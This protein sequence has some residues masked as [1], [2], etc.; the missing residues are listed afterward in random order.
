MNTYLFLFF[1]YTKKKSKIS[2]FMNVT[3][4][5]TVYGIWITFWYV[6]LKCPAMLEADHRVLETQDTGDV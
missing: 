5:N 2:M 3:K 6:C 1:K 4:T